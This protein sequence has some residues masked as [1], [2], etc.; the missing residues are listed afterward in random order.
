[1]P[2][3]LLARIVETIQFSEITIIANQRMWRR[4]EK[5]HLAAPPAWEKRLKID[6]VTGQFDLRISN[7][8]SKY[9]KGTCVAKS[10]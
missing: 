10:N 4:R 6:R 2:P 8:S 5:D 9:V 7:Q 1:L 3:T